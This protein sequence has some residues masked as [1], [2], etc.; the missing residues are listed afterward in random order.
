M[1]EVT[2]VVAKVV[3]LMAVLVD[4]VVAE[5]M[6]LVQGVLEIRATQVD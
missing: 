2:E 6:V 1:E 3:A 4:Q 5:H